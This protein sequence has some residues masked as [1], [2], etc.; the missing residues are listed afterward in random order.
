[1]TLKKLTRAES[2]ARA[3]AAR[4]VPDDVT[5]DRYQVQLLQDLATTFKKLSTADRGRLVAIGSRIDANGYLCLY[6]IIDALGG[7]IITTIV[8]EKLTIVTRA[9]SYEGDN[10][11]ELLM[12]II[13]DLCNAKCEI[14]SRNDDNFS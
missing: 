9:K 12:E 6:R 14:E 11:F 4:A 8:G 10:Q 7:N 5:A 2:T 3:R 13:E 1:M